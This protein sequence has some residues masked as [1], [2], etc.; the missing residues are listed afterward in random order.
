M[1]ALY[2][3]HGLA[4]S[5]PDAAAV[6]AF[7]RAL[8]ALHGAR[9][10]VDPHVDEALRR[11]PSCV[12]AR[13]LRATASLLASDRARDPQ[14]GTEIAALDRCLRHASGRERAHVAALRAWQRGKP[15]VAL[16]LYDRLLAEHPC[17]GLALRAAHALDFRLGQREMLRDRIARVLPHW[18]PSLPGYGYVLGMY[19]FGLV[20][21]ADDQGAERC[22]RRA[23]ETNPDN[24]AAMHVIA[25]VLE[26]RGHAREGAAWLESTRE[27]WRH[28]AAFAFHNA[29]H[30]A[31]FHLELDAPAAALAI[32]DDVLRPARTSATSTLID[33]SAL[34]WRLSLREV[35]VGS[36]F[37][38]LA[39]AWRGRTLR[40][41]RAFTL[42]HAVMALAAA[43]DDAG[44]R[45][46]A[47]L[48]REDRITRKA[49]LA[50]DLALAVPLCE[51]LR[52]F[53][54][55]DYR[56]A[57][58]RLSTLRARAEQC[59][60]SIAQCDLLHLTLVESALRSRHVPL[61]RALTA[62]RKARRPASRLDRWL[63]AR[64]AFAPAT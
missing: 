18:R 15:R 41:A 59:G 42:A 21:T 52:A 62:E 11:D 1:P 16:V 29:W 57:V 2:D 58:E 19:A 13:C 17:D 35:D 39:D 3:H 31:L 46:V 56:R 9:G 60:G 22:A 47:A 12:I 34:L 8:A 7:E 23:L 48:L 44:A 14:V 61:A 28:S 32:H 25:H 38:A 50:E 36:R 63:F 40:G 27:T 53:A 5:T 20:E 4:V 33:A 49:N 43:G 51:A 37:R 26:M 30:L 54:G 10:S 55:A 6:D 24:A 45:D 64:A